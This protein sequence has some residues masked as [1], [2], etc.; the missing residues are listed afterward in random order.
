MWE[1]WSLAL[2]RGCPEGGRIAPAGQWMRPAKGQH[3]GRCP[4]RVAL[5]HRAH[6]LSRAIRD[7]RQK[8]VPT[9]D[10]WLSGSFW[11]EWVV[12]RRN[13]ETEVTSKKNIYECDLKEAFG[14][15]RLDEIGAGEI[16][17]FR[18]SLGRDRDAK[19]AHAAH[20]P[21]DQRA[22]ACA[23]TARGR[24]GGLRG[25]QPG[26]LAENGWPGERGHPAGR[27]AGGT[28]EEAL[29]HA[30]A[31]VRDARRAVRGEPVAAAVMDGPQSGS[32][33]R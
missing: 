15:L 31:H 22:G 27:A 2:S 32:T 14:E 17:E 13:K 18:A 30:Q 5:A 10:E 3:E 28:A 6:H 20:E 21:G 9:F 29:A 26:W 1:R 4:G 16:A 8:E 19:G 12:A 24:A 7:D 11:R 25:S 23:P 33:R